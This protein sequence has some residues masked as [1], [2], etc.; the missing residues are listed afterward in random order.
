MIK[1]NSAPTASP[2]AEAA[3]PK[4]EYA[5]RR[6]EEMIVTRQ[7]P[8]GALVSEVQLAS[9]LALG[10]TPVREA[11]ARLQHVGFVKT[12]PRRGTLVS[13][14]DVRQQLELLE[15]RRV[16]EQLMVVSACS[17]ATPGERAQMQ[18]L[19]AEIVAA[20]DSGDVHAY[21]RVNRAIHDIEVAAAHNSMLANTMEIIHAQ[22]RRFWY[23]HVQ[24]SGAFKE[25][26][27]RHAAVLD[28]IVGGH[29]TEAS[30]GAAQLLLFLDRL[31]RSAIESF[32]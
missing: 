4:A 3:E 6:L 23:V 14:V 18:R 1:K 12:H 31:T 7:L 5:Y 2:E 13:G 16:L 17:R 32:R 11:L 8:P 24:Q 26:A 10:R 30:D 15:V 28:A 19:A 25:G 29:E 9:E 27:A 20:A 22:S 21:F